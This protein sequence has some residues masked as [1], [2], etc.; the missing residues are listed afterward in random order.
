ML[1]YR[2]TDENA[3]LVWERRVREQETGLLGQYQPG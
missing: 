3:A 2:I 1:A